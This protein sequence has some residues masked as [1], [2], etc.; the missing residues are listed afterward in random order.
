MTATRR[1]DSTIKHWTLTPKQRKNE[2]MS[3]EIPHQNTKNQN[4]KMNTRR[5]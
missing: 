2:E 4:Q 5:R 3:G 1:K